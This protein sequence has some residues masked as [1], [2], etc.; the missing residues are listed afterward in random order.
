MFNLATKKTYANIRWYLG[1]T[2]AKFFYGCYFSPPLPPSPPLTEIFVY[3]SKVFRNYY[4]LPN[5]KFAANASIPD[6]FVVNETPSFHFYL[7]SSCNFCS[8]DCRTQFFCLAS[9]NFVRIFSAF[10]SNFP[11]HLH[12]KKI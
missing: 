8:L 3:V 9:S 4:E 7:R 11:R 1:Q 10:F 2:G 5:F 6:H 12:I